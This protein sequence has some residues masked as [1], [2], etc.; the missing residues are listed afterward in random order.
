M[1]RSFSKAYGMANLRLGWIYGHSEIVDPMHR[2]RPPFNTTGVSQA[3]GI[4]ALDDQDWIRHCVSLNKENL[5]KFLANM[6]NLNIPMLPFA[7][8]FVMARFNDAS[9]VYRYLGERGLIVRPM[10]AYDL[11]DYL[12]ITVGKSEE[13][14]ELAGVIKSCPLL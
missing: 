4:A 12:R 11:P 6:Q 13:M 9:A 1:A 14:D 10:G 5:S 7:S 3:A 8:N 2:V